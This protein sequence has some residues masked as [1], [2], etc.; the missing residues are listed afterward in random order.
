MSYDGKHATEELDAPNDSE[1]SKEKILANVQSAATLTQNQK[2]RAQTI[3]K[4]VGE[5]EQI[6]DG[7]M[8]E[9]EKHDDKKFVY[10]ENV[11]LFSPSESN[12]IS[13]IASP[14]SHI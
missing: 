9:A 13:G 3:I 11:S 2:E 7:K 14:H 6:S 4:L 10:H 8:T 12:K 5:A 1:I